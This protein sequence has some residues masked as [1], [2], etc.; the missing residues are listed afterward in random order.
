MS[1]LKNSI[2]V[3]TVRL[4][5][6]IRIMLLS[7]PIIDIKSSFKANGLISEVF[8]NLPPLLAIVSSLNKLF[9]L[10]YRRAIV[11]A[12]FTKLV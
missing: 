12:L 1:L 4:R 9:N 6:I 5:R 8:C 11:S 10:E 2:T 7:D 3:D